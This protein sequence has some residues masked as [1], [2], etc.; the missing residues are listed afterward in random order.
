MILGVFELSSS[1]FISALEGLQVF[2]IYAISALLCQF[3]LLCELAKMKEEMNKEA[4]DS[5]ASSG[6]KQQAVEIAILFKAY[7]IRTIEDLDVYK[8]PTSTIMIIQVFLCNILKTGCY[9]TTHLVSEFR[10]H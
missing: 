5:P 10:I 7:V 3:I 9:C 4:D 2:I 6:T 1:M 8:R